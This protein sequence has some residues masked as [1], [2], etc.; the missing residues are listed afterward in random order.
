MF[1]KYIAQLLNDNNMYRSVLKKITLFITILQW[2]YL[3]KNS[4]KTFMKST[5]N[6]L[7]QNYC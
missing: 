2:Q 6:V 1:I 5:Q 7:I 4:I 3:L